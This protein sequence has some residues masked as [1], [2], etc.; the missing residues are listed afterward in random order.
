MERAEMDE[1]DDILDVEAW[2]KLR[3]YGRN[4]LIL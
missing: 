3:E 4:G 2:D 1:K